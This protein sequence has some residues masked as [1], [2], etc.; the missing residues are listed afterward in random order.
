[1]NN[2]DLSVIQNSKILVVGDVFLDKFCYGKAVRLSPEAPVPVV[3]SEYEV[4]SSGGAANVAVNL[5][6][7]GCHSYLVG[8]AG[9]DVFGDNLKDLLANSRVDYILPKCNQTIVKTRIIANDQHL[10]RYDKEITFT[11]QEVDSLKL[12]MAISK[13]IKHNNIKAIIV[14][15]YNKGT[16][17]QDV[18]N[19]IKKEFIGPVFVDPKP[20][21]KHYYNGVFCITPNLTEGLSMFG[22]NLD[23]QSLTELAKKELNLKCVLFTMSE[24]G[25][26]C[27]NESG[28]FFTF[29][30]HIIHQNKERHHRIDVAGAGDTVISC[31]TACFVGGISFERAAAIANVAAAI[32]VN[33]MGTSKCTFDELQS[34]LKNFKE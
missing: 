21:N 34:E 12:K 28:S 2:I 5:S 22:T 33:K 14:S 31:L 27:L 18:V 30:S 9:S 20:Q 7:L 15:D 32:V 17:T 3:R 24:H 8:Y 26:A 11:E 6:S 1:M 10:V 25:I 23:I 16:I 13:T 4:E 29:P 19:F